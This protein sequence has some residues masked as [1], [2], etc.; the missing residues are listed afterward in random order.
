MLWWLGELGIGGDR[1]YSTDDRRYST[2]EKR[3][4]PMVRGRPVVE[5]RQTSSSR[6]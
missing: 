1:R 2:I 5:I 6:K 3:G 4:G